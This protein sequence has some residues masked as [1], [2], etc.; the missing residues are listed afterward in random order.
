MENCF[1]ILA[2]Y[3]GVGDRINLAKTC[4]LFNSFNNIYYGFLKPKDLRQCFFCSASTSNQLSYSST[5]CC[6]V[7]TK[8]YKDDIMELGLVKY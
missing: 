3:L 4:T 5:H 2:S 7:C 6:S 1:T 8:K